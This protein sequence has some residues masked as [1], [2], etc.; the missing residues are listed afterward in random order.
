IDASRTRSLTRFLSALGVPQVGWATAEL[1]GAEFGSIENLR[2]A[3]EADL[4]RVPGVGPNMAREIHLFF[5]GE[6]GKLVEK[7]LKAGVQP[8]SDSTGRVDGPLSGQSFVF[9][10]TLGSLTRPE[11]EAL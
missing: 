2:E 8:K 7:L 5:R 10:G 9:T 1:L 4:L 6:G 3:S 11:A